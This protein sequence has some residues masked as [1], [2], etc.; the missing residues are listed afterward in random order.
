M[1]ILD[2]LKFV[3]KYM[4]E[5]KS[6]VFL[7][8]SGIII[9]IFT[10]TFFMFVS[11][12]LSNAVTEQ[13]SSLGGNILAVKSAEGGVSIGAPTGSGLTD[14]ELSEV[15]QVVKNA[16]YI[17]PG[18]F[19]SLIFDN[20]NTKFSKIALG[21]PDKYLTDIREDL[22]LKAYQGRELRPGDRG[23]IVIGYKIA[24]DNND[25]PIVKLGSSLKVGDNNFRVIGITQE[26][27]DLMIDSSIMMSFDDIK[28]IT[29]Q[30]TYSVFRISFPEGTDLGYM[31]Q[32]ID[33]KL[34]QKNKEKK[35]E[36]TSSDQIIKQFNNILGVLTG[37]VV[38]IS[39]IALLVGGINVMN[40]MHSN[41]IERI[42]EISVLKAVGA[43]NLDIL[44]MFLIESSFL[45]LFGSLIGIL[46]SFSLAKLLSNLILTMAG[47]NVPIYFNINFFLIVII[48]TMIF[49]TIFGTYPAISAAKIDPADNLRDE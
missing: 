8:L 48:S 20:S 31:K 4:F 29:G 17:A 46:L 28:K 36:I 41:V 43:R 26:Q 6:R 23:S 16:K 18:I 27:G 10:F 22:G 25:K 11:S 38:F 14:K 15:K 40:T 34:N 42:N 5:K 2:M 37:I 30:T 32:V 39:L 49:T 24:Y 45:G 19:T 33:K 44:G 7:T 35:V 3:F 47:F 13:F 9:G 21:Y 12:G 1:K